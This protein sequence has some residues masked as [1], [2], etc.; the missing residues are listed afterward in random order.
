MKTS[1][2]VREIMKEKDIGTSA[3]ADRIGKPPRLVS[4]RLRQ[5]NISVDKLRELL[6]VMDY[7]IVIMPRNTVLKGNEY[8]I[9]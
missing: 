9:E 7:K 3:L 4:D 6:R 2:A 8:E 1:E 5:D